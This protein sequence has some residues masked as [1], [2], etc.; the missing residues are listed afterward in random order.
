MLVPTRVYTKRMNKIFLEL[1]T[2]IKTNQV[3]KRYPNEDII[4]ELKHLY[5][6][7]NKLY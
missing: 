1:H 2:A 6:M 3:L 4:I 5:I 7:L